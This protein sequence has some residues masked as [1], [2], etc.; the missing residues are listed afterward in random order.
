[1][2]MNAHH[3]MAEYCSVPYYH[4]AVVEETDFWN[5]AKTALFVHLICLQH[6]KVSTLIKMN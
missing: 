1:M 2:Q 4:S 5:F 3:S 6:S